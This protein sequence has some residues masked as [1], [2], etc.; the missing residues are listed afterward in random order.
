MRNYLK[1]LREKKGFSQ[2]NVELICGISQ[3]YYC[4]IENGTRQTDMSLSIMEKL[5]KAFDVPL[6]QIIK[7]EKQYQKGRKT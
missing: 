1:A 2:Q 6:E 5:A 3:Q 7:D 4:M